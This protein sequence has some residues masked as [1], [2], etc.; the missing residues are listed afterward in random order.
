MIS[1]CLEI[2]LYVVGSK[3]ATE[4]ASTISVKRFTQI[5]ESIGNKP[6]AMMAG[7]KWYSTKV[8]R[9]HHYGQ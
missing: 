4:K 5:E 7:P 1:I 8:N 6:P 2:D 3:Q 9:K